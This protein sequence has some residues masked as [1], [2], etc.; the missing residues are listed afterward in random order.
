MV[1]ILDS[2]SRYIEYYG[3]RHNNAESIADALVH[4]I[5]NGKGF[6]RT[7]KHCQDSAIISSMV[8]TLMRRLDIG[9]KTEHAY[10]PHLIGANERPHKEFADKIRIHTKSNP[11]MW[12]LMLPWAQYSHNVSVHR[13][14]GCT[15]LYLEYG[16]PRETRVEVTHLPEVL[17]EKDVKDVASDRIRF[18]RALSEEARAKDLKYHNESIQRQQRVM[19]TLTKAETFSKGTSVLVYMPWVSKGLNNKLADRWHGPFNIVSVLSDGYMLQDSN[20]NSETSQLIKVAKGRVRRYRTIQGDLDSP[21]SLVKR[22][23]GVQDWVLPGLLQWKAALEPEPDVVDDEKVV[24]VTP[25]QLTSLM[26]DLAK[27]SEA[28]TEEQW[29]NRV[30]IQ[31]S[32]L[33]AQ[34]YPDGR[35]AHASVSTA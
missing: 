2:S 20:E 29:T 13:V 35:Q 25:H 34:Y 14:T 9:S 22:R 27:P 8:Q 15:P 5:C 1:C 16:N 11:T 10:S 3:C 32:M 12:H 30:V 4:W 26:L 31:S 18:Y 33:V 24:S 23:D 19:D 28:E 7:I 17:S 6:P 21:E